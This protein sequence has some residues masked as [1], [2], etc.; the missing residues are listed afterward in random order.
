MAFHTM[1]I[2][3]DVVQLMPRITCQLSYIVFDNQ[4]Y[5]TIQSL[6][7]TEAQYSAVDGLSK[8]HLKLAGETE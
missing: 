6:F 4:Y 7:S 5:D 3:L 2:K 1:T 8:D